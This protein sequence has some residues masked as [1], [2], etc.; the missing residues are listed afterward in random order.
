MLFLR[1]QLLHHLSVLSLCSRHDMRNLGVGTLLQI[2][3]DVVMSGIRVGR[4]LIETCLINTLLRELQL[5]PL[6]FKHRLR[7]RDLGMGLHRAV[8]RMVIIDASCLKV[9]CTWL[10]TSLAN[11]IS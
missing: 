3:N 8:R 4:S 11:C 9:S 7:L 2:T 1:T 10:C 5:S 6:A